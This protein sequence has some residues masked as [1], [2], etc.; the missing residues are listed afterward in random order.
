MSLDKAK[1]AAYDAARNLDPAHREAR[2]IRQRT[3]EFQEKARIRQRNPE[4]VAK[5]RPTFMSRYRA[6]RQAWFEL[7]GGKCCKCGSTDRLECDHVERSSKSMQSNM[8][9]HVSAVRRAAELAKCQV[10]C[11]RCHREKTN[12][13][14]RRVR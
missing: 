12:L 3:P 14:L 2:R 13:E 9:W 1:K 11:R 7:M 8:I 5:R 10:L 6:L 4:Y